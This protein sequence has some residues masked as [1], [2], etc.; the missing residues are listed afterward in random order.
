MQSEFNELPFLAEH[1]VVLRLNG[2][3]DLLLRFDEGT[4]AEEVLPGQVE[5]VAAN[6]L[7]F[8]RP[9]PSRV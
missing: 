6:G 4:E 8:G 7:K 3:R 5:M 9:K 1:G 2:V